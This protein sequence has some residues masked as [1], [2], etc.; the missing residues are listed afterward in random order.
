MTI[1]KSTE[2]LTCEVCGEKWGSVTKCERLEKKH[3]GFCCPN[4]TRERGEYEK[5]LRGLDASSDKGLKNG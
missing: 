1:D 3:C 5:H 4:F 2:L